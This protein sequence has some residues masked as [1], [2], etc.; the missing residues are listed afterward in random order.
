MY[1]PS[2]FQFSNDAEKIAFM[3]RYSFATIVTT[4]DQMPIATHLPFL[5][6]DT[7]DKLVLSSHLAIAN[8]QAKYLEENVSLVIFSEPHA[9]ISPTHYDKVESVPTWDYMSIHA[10]GKAK[11][12]REEHLKARALE[13]MI[14][15]YE[16]NYLQQWGGFSDKYKKGLMQGIV[17]FE[18]EVTSLQGQQKLSQN[19]SEVERKRITDHL[20]KSENPVEKL[21]AEYIKKV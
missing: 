20:D 15:F 3:K 13:R 10:Y 6:D 11:I 7:S 12:I 5:I 21:I 17:A 4:K 18:L 19:K 8:E 14:Q 9:Y 2:N 1:T 16:A